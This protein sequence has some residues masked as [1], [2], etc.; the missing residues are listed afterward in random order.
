MEHRQTKLGKSWGEGGYGYF[1][2]IVMLKEI[3]PCQ[4]L[5]LMIMNFDRIRFSLLKLI[6][7]IGNLTFSFFFCYGFSY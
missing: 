5:V 2:V 4:I 6:L 7:S 1:N 3:K